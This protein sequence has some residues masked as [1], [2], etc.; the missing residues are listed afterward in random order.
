MLTLSVP[1]TDQVQNNMNHSENRMLRLKQQSVQQARTSFFFSQ[2]CWPKWFSS[3]ALSLVS[4]ICFELCSLQ[5]V[6][7]YNNFSAN[8]VLF[9]VEVFLK[10]FN[11]L[12]RSWS[13]SAVVLDFVFVFHVLISM[14]FLYRWLLYHWINKAR[15]KSVIVYCFQ[16]NVCFKEAEQLEYLIQS[17]SPS[18]TYNMILTPLLYAKL[19]TPMMTF[20]SGAAAFYTQPSL[21]IVTLVWVFL[22]HRVLNSWNSVQLID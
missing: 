22:T 18:I 16:V 9:M 21:V 13:R 7:F 1:Q 12:Q 2:L 3:S 20:T 6:E 14:L 8:L 19:R 11:I 4:C 5:V 10:F 15:L 17:R